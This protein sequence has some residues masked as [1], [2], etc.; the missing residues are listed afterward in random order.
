MK[1]VSIQKSGQV[2]NKKIGSE[3]PEVSATQI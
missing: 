2:A 3:F 1:A